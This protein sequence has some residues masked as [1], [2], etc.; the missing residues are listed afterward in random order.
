MYTNQIIFMYSSSS[1]N[2]WGI[3]ILF[4]F[5]FPAIGLLGWYLSAWLS[6]LQHFIDFMY[7]VNIL[8]GKTIKEILFLAHKLL[9]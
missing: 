3:I 1:S 9:I 8:R 6:L 4:L 5:Y 2:G 7:P